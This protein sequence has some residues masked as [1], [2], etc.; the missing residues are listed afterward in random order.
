MRNTAASNN[1]SNSG[2]YGGA[3]T[4][5]NS[6]YNNY[7][8]NRGGGYNN[9]GG[10]MNNL[11]GFN[12]GGFQQPMTGGFQGS[13]MGGYQATPMGG[14]QSYGGF[15]NRG[16]MAGGMRGGPMGMRGGRG[17]MNAS[18]MMGMPMGGMG[19]GGMGT[20]GMNMPQLGGGMGMQGMTGS[21][22]Q[23]P[24]NPPANHGTL[25]I[26]VGFPAQN[27][28]QAAHFSPSGG[29]DASAPGALWGK[30]DTAGSNPSLAWAKYTQYPPQTSSTAPAPSPFRSHYTL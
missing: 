17:G 11:S 13:G 8:G 19:L 4:G 2:A 21:Y 3:G 6:G 16:A 14:M 25:A 27:V 29:V 28:T 9:R 5:Q 30:G 7:R 15:Q 23:P 20:M 22:S 24:V 1:R 12:R 10:N 26:A 18:P